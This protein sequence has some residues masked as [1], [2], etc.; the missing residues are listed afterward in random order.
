[1]KRSFP[2]SGRMNRPSGIQKSSGPVRALD[3]LRATY[4]SLKKRFDVGKS[5]VIVT[6]GYLRSEQVLGNQNQITFPI[7]TNEGTAPRSTERRLSI[8]DTFVITNLGFRIG[9]QAATQTA[10]QVKLESFV[11]ASVFGASAAQ[12]D[13]LYNGS[14]AIKVGSIT[15][16]E[17]LDMLRFQLSSIAQRGAILATGGAT[18]ANSEFKGLADLAEIVPT[19]QFSGQEKNIVQISLPEPAAM[20]P[21]TG[22]NICVFYASGFLCQNAAPY[23]NR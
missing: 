18:T 1:M 8:S 14:V 10:G 9:Q 13:I 21:A 11:N 6:P 17:A 3:P 15:Y 7:L 22:D 16:I 19:I 4:N 5:N 23:L 20:A 12:L 2:S